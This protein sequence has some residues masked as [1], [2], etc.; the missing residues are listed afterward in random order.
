MNRQIATAA[1]KA[2]VEEAEKV[3]CKMNITVVDA[4]GHLVAFVRMDDAWLGSVDISQKKAKTAAFFN[5]PSG[6]LGKMSQPGGSLYGIEHSNEGL[7][8]FAGGLPIQNAAGKMIGAIGVSGDTVENDEKVAE[9]GK[10]A[11][12]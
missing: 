8:T 9:A 6:T 5:L 1:I 4:G 10:R 3:N 2:A 11:D 7:I 12:K